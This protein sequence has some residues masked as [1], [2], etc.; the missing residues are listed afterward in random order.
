[1]NGQNA[2]ELDA[3]RIEV[4]GWSQGHKI[5][6]TLAAASLGPH[7]RHGDPDTSGDQSYLVT[8]QSTTVHDIYITGHYLEAFFELSAVLGACDQSSHIE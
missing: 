1:M 2:C 4:K 5:K 6:E 3:G 7:T 8:M